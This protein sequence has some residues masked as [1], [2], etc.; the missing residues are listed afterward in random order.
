[1]QLRILRLLS[2]IIFRD[3]PLIA[4]FT[5]PGSS[6]PSLYGISPM[7]DGRHAVLGFLLAVPA[8][9]TRLGVTERGPIAD[10][11]DGCREPSS[12][13]LRRC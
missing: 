6:A 1:M 5:A 13:A 10:P 3:L 9:N 2:C 7:I 8:T 4:D 12:E 11:A